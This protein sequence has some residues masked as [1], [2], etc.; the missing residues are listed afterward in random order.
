ML[1]KTL[2]LS[3]QEILDHERQE[4]ECPDVGRWSTSFGIVKIT[5]FWLEGVSRLTTYRRI[6]R[7]GLVVAT[8]SCQSSS[9]LVVVSY[10]YIASSDM[11]DTD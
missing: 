4:G 6:V 11:V 5:I 2:A 7:V 3:S 9:D 8:N 1:A 10:P